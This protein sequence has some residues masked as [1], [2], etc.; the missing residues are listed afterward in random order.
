[1]DYPTRWDEYIS[2]VLYAYRTKIHST[3]K[4]SPYELLFGIVPKALDSRKLVG[5]PLGEERLVL[6]DYKRDQA[7]TK[8]KN[9]QAKDWNPSVKFKQGDIVLIKRQKRLKIQPIWYETPFVI[10]RAHENDTYDLV[11]VEGEFF[12]SSMNG[13]LLKAYHIE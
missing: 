11:D 10:Y 6:M 9:K 2:S 7:Q 3:L 4:Y 1:M 13:S 5:Q 12:R 8:L